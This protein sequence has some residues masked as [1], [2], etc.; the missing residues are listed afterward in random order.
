[1]RLLNYPL[2]II[3]LCILFSCSHHRHPEK[4]IFRY[5]EQT[6]IASLD[7]AFAKNQS[8]MWAIHQLYNT[9]IEVDEN[10]HLKPSLAK[11]WEISP[12]NL[13]F[14]FHLR[15]DVNFHD[16]AAF[17]NGMGR[18]LTAGDVVFSFN[19]IIDKNVASPGAWIF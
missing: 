18:K 9:L 3:S 19:R 7:P 10:M 13:R 12:D 16:D 17:A 5:N 4:K 1:M 8:I 6:G 15:T 14:V 11:S 2:S